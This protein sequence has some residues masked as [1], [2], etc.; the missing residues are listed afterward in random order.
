MPCC[1]LG[2]PAAGPATLQEHAQALNLPSSHSDLWSACGQGHLRP[3]SC[4]ALP[5]PGFRH[6]YGLK[7]VAELSLS[8]SVL[9]SGTVLS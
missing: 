9:S 4:K 8:L 1:K 7:Q 6:G 3:G 2:C 5:A